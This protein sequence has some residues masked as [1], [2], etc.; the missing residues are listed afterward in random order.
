M[1][2]ATQI[3]TALVNNN[4]P[5]MKITVSGEIDASTAILLDTAILNCKE[6]LNYRV[7]FDFNELHYI[8][9]AG[10]GVFIAHI[11][12][13][14]ANSGDFVMYGLNPNVY[15]IFDLLGLKSILH[16]VEN[17]NEAILFYC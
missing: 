17:E 11:E 2:S 5:I 15:S 16:I 7:I 12:D 8:S 3:E 13:F 1:P 9:S 14:K 4:K 6:S 10:L